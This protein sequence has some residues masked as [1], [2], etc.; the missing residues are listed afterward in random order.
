MN[1]VTRRS[2]RKA[3][4]NATAA[5]AS[6]CLPVVLADDLPELIS[7]DSSA[8]ESE[9]SDCETDDEECLHGPCGGRPCGADPPPRSLRTYLGRFVA[10]EFQVDNQ[11]DL[12]LF[13]GE[14]VKYEPST[15]L[16]SVRVV[17]CICLAIYMHLQKPFKYAC[18]H[19]YRSNFPTEPLCLTS[20]MK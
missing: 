7:H 18:K 1:T 12:S 3:S 19:S 20:V 9:E 17:C 11:E 6:A 4:T 15:K 2:K 13:W 5:M 16:F 8:S 10:K 14:V